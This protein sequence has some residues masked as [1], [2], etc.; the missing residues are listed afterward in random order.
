[1]WYVVVSWHGTSCDVQGRLGLLRFP[2][3]V[4]EYRA[5]RRL[6]YQSQLKAAYQHE[7]ILSIHIDKRFIAAA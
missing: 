4:T 3:I 5:Y 7:L 6:H 2:F 1:M